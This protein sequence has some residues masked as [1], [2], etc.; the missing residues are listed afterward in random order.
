ML[1]QFEEQN[2]VRVIFKPYLTPLGI[3]KLTGIRQTR[4]DK[5]TSGIQY[6]RFISSFV[7]STI[8]DNHA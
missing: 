8:Y 1:D 4:L 5:N 3:N 7:N 2:A 6:S